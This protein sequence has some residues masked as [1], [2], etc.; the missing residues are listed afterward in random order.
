MKKRFSPKKMTKALALAG[1]SF[2]SLHLLGCSDGGGDVVTLAAGTVDES[3]EVSGTPMPAADPSRPNIVLVVSDDQRWDL[4]SARG[5]PHLRTPHLDAVTESG[6]MMENAFV[7]VALC[8]PSRGALLTGR[9]VHKASAPRIVWENNS[10]LET[11]RTLAE[12]M[13]DAG[14]TTAYVGKWHLGKGSQP[15]R[16]FDHWESFDWLGQ[17]FDP[18][19]WV[20]GKERNF[21]GFVDDVLSRRAARVISSSDTTDRPLF[22]VVALKEPHLHFE[23]P[24]RHNRALENVTIDRPE[25][26]DE[27][28]AESGKLQEIKDWL[29]MDNFHCGLNCFDYSWDKYIK[30]HY[31]A[32]MGLDDAIGEIRAAIA[33]SKAADNTLFIYTSDNGYSLGD[34]GLTEKHFVYEE[35]IRVPLLV[36]APGALDAGRV[37]GE[38]VTTIDIAPTILDYASVDIPASMTGKS[39][40]PLLEG[41]AQTTS[42]QQTSWRDQLFFMYEKA[43]VAVRTSSM[44]LIRSLTVDGHYELYDLAADPRETRNVYADPAYVGA[45][46]EM[47]QR[48]KNIIEENGWSQ[49]KSYPV[50]T[51]LVSNPVPSS[52]A[53]ALSL[54][55]SEQNLY[56]SVMVDGDETVVNGTVLQWR[57]LEVGTDKFPDRFA[58]KDDPL[59]NDGQSVLAILPMELK[60]DWD[61]FVE[62]KVRRRAHVWVYQNGEQLFTTTGERR[63]LDVANPALFQGQNQLIMRFD[64]SGAMDAKVDIESTE[65][66][67]RLTLEQRL[68]GNA[69]GRFDAKDSWQPH[70]DVELGLS[71]GLLQV[72]ATGGDPQIVTENIYINEPVDISFSYISESDVAANLYWRSISETFSPDE[73]QSFNFSAGELQTITLR[74]GSAQE[75]DAL[76]LDLEGE[77]SEVSLDAITVANLQGVV[78]QE[79]SFQ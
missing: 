49:R 51:L 53:H 39:L 35:P 40:R 3:Q 32:V 63:P 73:R 22:M 9:E 26:Y 57:S 66:T 44:K 72:S 54:A 14:Y 20:N 12:D 41:Q 10:F 45:R 24:A 5:H 38:L 11:Q 60:T 58:L 7:P 36:D 29:G 68:L 27:D 28:F 46:R 6:A 34:H 16:G 48:L 21:S 56:A 74:V 55:L 50:R 17:F 64:D 13:K 37:P 8:S 69:P 19:I 62:V 42:D 23:H 2:C 15:K 52:D 59:A 76:R 61:P 65:D 47:R 75:V 1:F 78:L 25:T 79:W 71:A 77:S 31:R 4:M 30:S 43:Q 70:R 18:T 33:S 67:V